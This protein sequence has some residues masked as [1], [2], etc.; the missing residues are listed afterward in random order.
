[1]FR[2]LDCLSVEGTTYLVADFRIIC[3]D[4]LYTKYLV[5]A[6]FGIILY[7]L[8]IP[9]F[10]FYL[11]RNPWKKKQF[12]NPRVRTQIG[13]LYDGY[14]ESNWYWELLDISHKGFLSTILIICPQYA[15]MRIGMAFSMGYAICILIRNPYFRK[16]DD[17]LHLFVQTA[18]FCLFL[19][20]EILDRYIKNPLSLETLGEG[21]A[22]FSLFVVA[23]ITIIT[24]TLQF[25]HISSKKF[26]YYFNPDHMDFSNQPRCLQF[27]YR[28]CHRRILIVENRMKN[29]YNQARTSSM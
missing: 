26:K 14:S 1:M 2:L 5:L 13:L 3:Y 15:Q 21:W 22:S 7:T 24:F 6:S 18:F 23:F 16:G 27:L 11:L 19:S 28:S 4:S 9:L 12:N 17:R 20:G 25:A 8:G 29:I 10:F